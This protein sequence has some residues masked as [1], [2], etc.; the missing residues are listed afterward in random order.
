MPRDNLLSLFADFMCF[1][2][3]VAV[4]QRRGYRRERRTYGDIHALA[5][6]WS[7]ALS[8][9]G[10]LAGDRILL[11]GTNSAEWSPAFGGFYCVVPW[12]YLWTRRHPPSSFHV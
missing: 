4:I 11:W 7:H 3:D 5:L 2:G 12:S 6:F 1:A 9:R 10:I 8:G